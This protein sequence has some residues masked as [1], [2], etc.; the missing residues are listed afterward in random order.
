MNKFLILILIPFVSCTQ[1][2]LEVGRVQDEIRSVIDRQ[3]SAWN[4]HNIEE[5]MS[6]Y[7]KSDEMTFQSGN[8]RLEG[9]EALFNRYKTNYAGEKMGELNFSDIKIKALTNDYAYVLGRWRVEQRDSVKEGLYTIIL[10]RFPD[11]WKIIHDQS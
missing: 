11:G 8:N 2:R 6:D 3:E 9:W 7:W 1:S 5:F 10:K 4:D